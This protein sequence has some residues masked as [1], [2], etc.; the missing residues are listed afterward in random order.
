MSF[1][2]HAPKGCQAL[3]LMIAVGTG[4]IAFTCLVLAPFYG[5]DQ[6]QKD[7]SNQQAPAAT[8]NGPTSHQ[9]I[10]ASG[11]LW[12]GVDLYTR[13]V[14]GRM[15]YWSRVVSATTR[16]ESDSDGRRL[17]LILVRFPSGEVEWKSRDMIVEGPFFVKA[18]D[19]A[20]K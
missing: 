15:S 6:Q 20:I 19:P 17:R 8:T 1:G 5:D 14:D 7:V 3:L 16:I 4:I 10:K 13:S 18:D 9:W 12:D 2:K 11:N